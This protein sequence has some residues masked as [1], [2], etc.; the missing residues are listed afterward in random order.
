MIR[1]FIRWTEPAA[2]AT[3]V[4]QF[5]TLHLCASPEYTP[6]ESLG[7]ITGQQIE[8]FQPSFA[9]NAQIFPRGQRSHEVPLVFWR[10]YRDYAEATQAKFAYI[11][12]WPTARLRFDFIVSAS[13]GSGA[14]W[15][16]RLKN[17]A[18]RSLQ[19]TQQIGNVLQWQ[20]QVVG[21]QLEVPSTI[22]F[23]SGTFTFTR[24]FNQT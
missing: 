3:G 10:A 8:T 12:E 11:N 16:A 4:P 24:R 13:V 21:S 6:I 19:P 1:V 22:S 17:C 7:S 15:T 2:T 9:N 18:L 20:V 14:S 5:K 23:P